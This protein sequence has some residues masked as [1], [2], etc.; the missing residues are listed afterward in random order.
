MEVA[1][2]GSAWDREFES[3]FLQR[4]VCKLSVP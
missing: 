1:L 2:M 3:T 4:R